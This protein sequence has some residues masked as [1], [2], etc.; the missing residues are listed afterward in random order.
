MGFS[1][2]AAVAIMLIGFLLAAGVLFPTV[3]TA[4]SETGDAFAA[5]A[6]QTQD[7]L[8]TEIEIESSEYNEDAETG[9]ETFD[10][11]VTNEGTTTLDVADTDLLLNGIYIESTHYEATIVDGT[12]EFE[13]DVWY[14]GSALEI[15]INEGTIDETYYD[16]EAEDEERSGTI[17]DLL[18]DSDSDTVE[19]VKVATQHGI[20]VSEDV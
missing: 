9:E 13:S 17:S 14:P 15:T 1:T 10:L 11:S 7:K 4:G 19:R 16:S 3:F 20:S 2:S 18:E 5:Q 8:N 12:D 6:D